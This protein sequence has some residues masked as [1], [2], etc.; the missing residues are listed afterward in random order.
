MNINSDQCHL[1]RLSNLTRSCWI[2]V[3]RNFLTSTRQIA[4]NNDVI[5]FVDGVPFC[6]FW[7]IVYHRRHRLS[8]HAIMPS[9]HHATKY[10]GS[11]VTYRSSLTSVRERSPNFAR[12]QLGAIARERRD[13]DL[14]GD[15]DVQPPQLVDLGVGKRDTGHRRRVPPERHTDSQQQHRERHARVHPEFLC[16][17]NE[18]RVTL[19]C[20]K[21]F[22]HVIE[23][24]TQL[25]KNFSS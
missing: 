11:S 25:T 17:A 10:V 9:C 2:F 13:G 18:K 20:N 15:L 21:W 19:M 6:I 12:E 1:D 3:Y 23:N 8:R 22:I 5:R 14:R 4:H 7:H 24:Y 16:N